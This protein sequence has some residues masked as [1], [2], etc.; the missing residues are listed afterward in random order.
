MCAEVGQTQI[1]GGL[2]DENFILVRRLVTQMEVAV[3]HPDVIGQPLH[4]VKHDH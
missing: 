1:G 2:F 3:G 4:D